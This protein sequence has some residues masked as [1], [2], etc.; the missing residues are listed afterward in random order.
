ML[1]CHNVINS[2]T[3]H[4]TAINVAFALELAIRHTQHV[5]THR[6]GRDLDLCVAN[7]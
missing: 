7:C 3:I 6:A 5:L 4:K 1:A 2:A